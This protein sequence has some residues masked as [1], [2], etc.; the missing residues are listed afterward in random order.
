MPR[1]FR[2]YT[3]GVNHDATQTFYREVHVDDGRLASR[4]LVATLFRLRCPACGRSNVSKGPLGVRAACPHCGSRFDRMEGN[5]LIS[6]P[7]SF[8]VT[9]LILLAAA[10]VLVGRF[11]FFDGLM[12]V[13]AALGTVTVLL[14][15][16]PMRVLTLWALWLFG[17]V[18]PDRLHEKGRHELPAADPAAGREAAPAG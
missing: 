10:L 5:E 12:A 1:A 3:R 6:I 18:Y 16:K 7:L 8:F 9:V 14:L 2:D 17:F 4:R 15:L 13:L 11:G